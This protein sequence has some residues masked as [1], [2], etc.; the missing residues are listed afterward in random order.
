M[1]TGLF[2]QD[3]TDLTVMED[4]TYIYPIKIKK[5]GLLLKIWETVLIQISGNHNLAYRLIKEN[6]TLQAGNLEGWEEVIYMLA[7]YKTMANGAIRKI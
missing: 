7:D 4:A 2:L 3:V 6:F 1:A 5:D